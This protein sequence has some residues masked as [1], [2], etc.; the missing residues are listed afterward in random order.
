MFDKARVWYLGNISESLAEEVTSKLK[1][2]E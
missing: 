1:S 2:K